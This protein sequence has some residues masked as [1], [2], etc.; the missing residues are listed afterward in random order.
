MYPESC[1]NGNIRLVG[2]RTEYEGRVE[3]CA[4]N[5]WGTVCDDGWNSI[6]ASVVCRQLDYASESKSY[7]TYKLTMFY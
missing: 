1:V 6:D 7:M 3:Y 5:V 4:N 2:G